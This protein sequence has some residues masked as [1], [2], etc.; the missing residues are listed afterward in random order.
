[1]ATLNARLNEVVALPEFKTAL[2]RLS[3]EPL[4]GTP[5]EFTELIKSDVAKWQPIVTS[6]NIRTD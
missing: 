5:A 3:T 2:A 1:V 6:L 4:G